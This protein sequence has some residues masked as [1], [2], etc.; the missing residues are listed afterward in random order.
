MGFCRYFI[1]EQYAGVSAFLNQPA[2]ESERNALM[3]AVGVMVPL[4]HGR[5]G[6]NWRHANGLKELVRYDAECG[7]SSALHDIEIPVL[8]WTGN[9]RITKMTLAP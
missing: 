1:H 5:L 8:T 6:K 9:W 7:L 4:S 3:L 2:A